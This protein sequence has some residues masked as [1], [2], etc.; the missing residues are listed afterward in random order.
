MAE[1]IS[2]EAVM[3]KCNDIWNNADETT[4]TGVDTINTIDKVTDFI[5]S[6][7]TVDVQPVK[8]FNEELLIGAFGTLCDFLVDMQ[9]CARDCPY[10]GNRNEDGEC[11]AWQVI[12]DIRSKR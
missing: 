11:N 8:T 5:E 2:R 4:Q 6:L 12:H 7:P 1:Y 10:S 3:S 9:L